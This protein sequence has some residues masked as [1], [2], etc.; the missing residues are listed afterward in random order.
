MNPILG[1]QM[2]ENQLKNLG[3]ELPAYQPPAWA[4]QSVT[5]HNGVGYVSGHVSKTGDIV[6]HPGKVGDEV[7]LEQAAE[8]ARLATLNALASLQFALGSLDRVR[9][10]L[11]VVV[12]VA[13]AKGFNQQPQVADVVS[14]LLREIFGEAGVHARSAVGVAELP[15]NSA[16]EVELVVALQP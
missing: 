15:R 3:I 13:S 11:K 12:F 9:Q 10:I 16:V 4:Y 1:N 5:Q 7:T 2:T 8:A 14:N 6:L